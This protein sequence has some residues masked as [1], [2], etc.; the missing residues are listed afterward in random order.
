MTSRLMQR[1]AKKRFTGLSLAPWEK[2]DCTSAST[3]HIIEI[4][5]LLWLSYIAY[6]A[7]D[8]ILELGDSATTKKRKHYFSPFFRL[9]RIDKSKR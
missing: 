5:P 7:F 8:D 1:K 3:Y 9:F 2:S 6:L 4:V